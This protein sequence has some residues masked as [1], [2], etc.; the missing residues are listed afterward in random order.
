MSANDLSALNCP[1]S[2]RQSVLL[3]QIETELSLEQLAWLSG[4]F[5]GKSQHN[6]KTKK[7]S[8]SAIPSH[9]QL[10]IIYGS[11]T[12]NAKE[13]AH[14]LQKK[15][16]QQAIAV[17]LFC[18]NEYK[19][20]DLVKETHLIFIVS[21]HGEGEPPD[22]AMLMHEFLQSNNTIKLDKLK[23]AV[24]GLGDSS[25]EFFCQSAKDFDAFFSK[26]GAHSL[27]PR[28]DCDVDY[29]DEASHW[30]DEVLEL[31][32]VQFLEVNETVEASPSL[33][34]S[35]MEQDV[36]D[37]KHPFQATLLTNQKITGC[38][39]T[40]D[41]RH[42]ELTLDDSNLQY[43]P[44][45]ALGVY[46]C[47]CPQL[48][49][50]ILNKVNLSADETIEFDGKVLTLRQALIEHYEITVTNP[51]Q[52]IAI[53]ELSGNQTLQKCCQDNIK[54]RQYANN[55]QLIDV[56]ANLNLSLSSSQFL[57]L[58]RKLTP[59]LYSIS[60]SQKEVGQEVHLTLALVEYLSGK[61]KR[62]GGASGFLALRADLQSKV[63]IFIE[64]NLN[65]RLPADNNADIIMIGA[66]TGI[67]PFRAFMQEREANNAQGKNWLFFGER[68]FTQDFLYQVEWQRWVK[69]G[70]LNQFDFA[71]S[72]DQAEKIYVQ[73]KIQE[74]AST[75]WQWLQKGAFIYVC[76][77]ATYMAKD[78]HNTL[79]SIVQQQ[80]GMDQEQAGHFLNQLRLEKRYQKDVY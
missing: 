60:S 10:T 37:K 4:Y 35:A 38:Y 61:N 67:A 12:G 6:F 19:P 71:F 39:S 3:E 7:S 18:A 41:I 45:D 47:N 66:G 24:L 28:L 16:M 27:F 69:N 9:Y 54:L 62:Y 11:Q 53:A 15:A 79:I 46:F 34:I 44:G 73:H 52:V 74:Q 20:R 5:W 2:E 36:Y 59:R 23:Y 70:L 64:Q 21:T 65:F 40:K 55:T 58:L 63:K 76:G 80:G 68:T 56:L 1:L 75:I 48:V 78:V 30:C 14:L 31:I 57:G 72:R 25:Y 8:Q 51:K 33:N 77:D 17:R 26:L 13:I 50:E 32:K 43:Q 22:D 49:D 29:D 42:L